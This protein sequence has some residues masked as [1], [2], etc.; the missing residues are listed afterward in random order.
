MEK[1]RRNENIRR[2]K[3]RKRMEEKGGIGKKERRKKN[4]SNGR[5]EVFWMW[6]FWACCP[7]LQK[8]ERRRTDP[9]VLKQ[10]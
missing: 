6:G 3:S 7:S 10:I 4:Q 9:G 1:G 5:E 2:E 8:Y